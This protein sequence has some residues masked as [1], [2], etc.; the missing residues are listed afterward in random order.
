MEVTAQ[1]VSGGA[2]IRLGFN[3]EADPTSPV[4]SFTSYRETVD[5]R[6]VYCLWLSGSGTARVIFKEV[7]SDAIRA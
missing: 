6:R 7:T 5:T 4:D 1:A 3:R 2:A